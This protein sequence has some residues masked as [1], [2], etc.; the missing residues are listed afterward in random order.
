[1]RCPRTPQQNGTVE[2]KHQHLLKVTRA[3]KFELHLPITYWGD[4]V[5]TA[6]NIINILPS[7]RLSFKSPYELLYHKA[8]EYSY[9]KSFGCLCYRSTDC[10]F[11]DKFA[12]RAHNCAFISYPFHQKWYKVLDLLTRKQYVTRHVTFVEHVFPF[13]YSTHDHTDQFTS[14]FPS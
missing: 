6:A 12:P 8:P 14:L 11:A 7:K 13:S 5:L 1:M 9:L 10:N 3:L 2:R 4:C